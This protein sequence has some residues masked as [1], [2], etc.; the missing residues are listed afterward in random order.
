M[1]IYAHG[2]ERDSMAKNFFRVKGSNAGRERNRGPGGNF[3]IPEGETEGYHLLQ[4]FKKEG[5]MTGLGVEIKSSPC[6][7][8]GNDSFWQTMLP[9]TSIAIGME[10]GDGF[11]KHCNLQN[12]GCR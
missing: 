8:G 3:K 9:G 1:K 2:H 4:E 5:V 12:Q 6:Q 11:I 7:S 10:I